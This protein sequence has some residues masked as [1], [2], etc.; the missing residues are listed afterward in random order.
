[1]KFEGLLS[2]PMILIILKNN[3]VWYEVFYKIYRDTKNIFYV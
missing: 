3:S 1:M 2:K